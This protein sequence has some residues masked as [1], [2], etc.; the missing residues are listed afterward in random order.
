MRVAMEDGDRPIETLQLVRKTLDVIAKGG[1]RIGKRLS[2]WDEWNEVACLGGRRPEVL[3]AWIGLRQKHDAAAIA[4]LGLSESLLDPGDIGGL[5]F[6][7][8]GVHLRRAA[9]IVVAADDVDGDECHVAHAPAEIFAEFCELRIGRL[10]FHRDRLLPKAASLGKEHSADFGQQLQRIGFLRL[11][12][13]TIRPVVVARRQDEWMSHALERGED[14]LVVIVDAGH[15]RDRRVLIVRPR[16][17]LEI[18]DVGDEGEVSG[19]ERFEHTLVFALLHLGVGHVA[20]QGEVEGTVL[21]D[22]AFACEREG[23]QQQRAKD[24]T[25]QDREPSARPLARCPHVFPRVLAF[26]AL[27][28]IA[29]AVPRAAGIGCKPR[30]PKR[31][32]RSRFRE[33]TFAVTRLGQTRAVLHLDPNQL[34]PASR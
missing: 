24:E 22:N 11:Q 32:N 17:E 12:R 7:V 10:I 15:R 4:R 8:L 31:A 20:D 1:G 25:P 19:V 33:Q 14:G 6:H 27:A 3:E 13:P 9:E 21:G 30:S 16:V 28:R 29:Q 23:C 2:A 26:Y 5:T 34:T 18:A